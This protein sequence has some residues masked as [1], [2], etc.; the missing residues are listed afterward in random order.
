MHR[1]V[2]SLDWK[3]PF[4]VFEDADHAKSILAHIVD[5]LQEAADLQRAR[6]PDAV[7]H[8]Y[9]E[10]RCWQVQLKFIRR[11]DY[12]AEWYSM[13]CMTCH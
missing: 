9:V 8:A 4:V 10:Q 5:A 12:A 13:T 7:A 3:L 6:P 11:G 2:R 1:Q